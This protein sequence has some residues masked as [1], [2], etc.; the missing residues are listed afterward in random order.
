MITMMKNRSRN[1]FI[2]TA[3]LNRKLLLKFFKTSDLVATLEARKDVCTAY[4]VEPD[5][6][7]YIDVNNRRHQELYTNG[8]A[9]ILV[10]VD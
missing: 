2:K 5:K 3:R 6:S 1:F 7:F 10:V 8:P 9:V 4:Y